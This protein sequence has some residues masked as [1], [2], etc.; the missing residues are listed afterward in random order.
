MDP[1]MPH[2]HSRTLAEDRGDGHSDSNHLTWKLHTPMEML[3][4]RR[5]RAR[6]LQARNPRSCRPG[7][8]TWLLECEICRLSRNDCTS[9]PAKGRVRH[10]EGFTTSG[11]VERVN[12]IVVGVAAVMAGAPATQAK[13][14]HEERREQTRPA[15]G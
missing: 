10:V 15:R 9:C 3:T 5:V 7:A 6:G 8:L 4:P 14:Q 13:V 1:A 2:L 11:A 12:G